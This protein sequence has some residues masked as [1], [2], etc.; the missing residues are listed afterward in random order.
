MPTYEY[1]CAHCGHRFDVIHGI[2]AEGPTACPSCGEGPVRK[3]FSAPSIHFKG[4]GWAKKDRSAARS[5]SSKPAADSGDGKDGG[6][7]GDAAA[8]SSDAGSAGPDKPA[9]SDKKAPAPAASGAT[10]SGS[11]SS[12]GSTGAA[13]D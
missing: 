8:A 5:K 4:T 9:A 10:G 2:F 12:S 13:S 3:G 7:S 1:V 6:G 11:G